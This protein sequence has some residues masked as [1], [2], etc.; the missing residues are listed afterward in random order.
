MKDNVVVGQ[1]LLESQVDYLTFTKPTEEEKSNIFVYDGTTKA[2]KSA[3]YKIDENK[4]NIDLYITYAAIT[5]PK[6]VVDCYQYAHIR[7]PYSA[8]GES[9]FNITGNTDF[10]FDFV[11]NLNEDA[12]HLSR[13]NVGNATGT[14][15]VT[16]QSDDTYTLEVNI[17]GLDSSHS[18]SAYYDGSFM[19]YN[20]S[21]PNAYRLQEQN[22]VV[23]R[24][25]AVAHADGLNTVYLSQKE[26]TNAEEIKDNSD[27]VV[28]TPEEF[29][30]DGLKGF[31]GDETR[32]K[33]SVTYDGVTYNQ[34]NTTKDGDEALAI[35]GNAD[36]KLNG[37]T[38]SIDFAV[39]NI[40]KLAM[41]T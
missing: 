12:F 30:N 15:S 14:I 25:A 2:L 32:A 8:L 20:L 37:T 41:P 26:S 23:L 7:V 24:S 27:I 35:G 13:G 16:Q 38:I 9:G 40:Y 34:T 39:Y 31:S 33:V 21:I 10:E 19:L 36:L 3:F 17:E 22:D 5:D 18:F 29:L 1:Y 6:L 28:V 4:T 11:D